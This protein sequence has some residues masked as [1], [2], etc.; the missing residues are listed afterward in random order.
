MIGQPVRDQKMARPLR[1]L[2][3][4]ACVETLQRSLKKSATRT[5]V[6]MDPPVARYRGQV[7]RLKILQ[8]FSFNERLLG[9][10]LKIS[11]TTEREIDCWAFFER[12]LPSKNHRDCFEFSSTFD[13]DHGDQSVHRKIIEKL[14]ENL[15]DDWALNRKKNVLRSVNFSD[16]Q[17]SLRGLC[18]LEKKGL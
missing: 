4:S 3:N 18:S 1:S 8:R 6:G 15:R 11:E 2:L 5:Q 14:L 13:A 10:H 7:L 9:D 12:L 17:G 16:T